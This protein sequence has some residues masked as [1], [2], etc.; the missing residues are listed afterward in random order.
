MSNAMNVKNA[1]KAVPVVTCEEMRRIDARAVEEYGIAVETLMENAGRAVAET[2]LKFLSEN[3]ISG[4]I[5]H[6]CGGGNNGGDGLVSARILHEK[7]VPVQVL[8]MKPSLSLKNA[9]LSNFEKIKKASIACIELPS[10][11][12]VEKEIQNAALLVDAL[13]GT[14]FKGAVNGPVK[15]AIEKM[16]ASGKPAIAVDVPSGLDADTGE[17][18]GICVKA[19]MTVTMGALKK[20][21]LNPASQRRTGKVIVADI[22]FPEEIFTK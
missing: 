10:M 1:S 6:L 8:L 20:G 19:K 3:K 15:E 17:A 5:L 13:L 9:T 18:E 11:N 21:F 16:N 4:T 22:G 14:G 7:K 12:I 2:V